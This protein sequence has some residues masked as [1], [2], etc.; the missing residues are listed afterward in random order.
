MGP[1]SPSRPAEPIQGIPARRRRCPPRRRH[2][3]HLL[4]HASRARA[5]CLYAACASAAP[6]LEGW[7]VAP[8]LLEGRGCSIAA[9]RLRC[10]S[11][12]HAATGEE[13]R[14]VMPPLNIFVARLLKRRGGSAAASRH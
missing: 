14:V 10:E 2:H 12:H 5:T 3:P 13:D 11:L 9:E 6:S 7:G 1:W 4:P 8:P